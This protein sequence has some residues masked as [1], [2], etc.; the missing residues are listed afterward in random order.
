MSAVL[1]SRDYVMRL[2]LWL[3]VATEALVLALLVLLN[4]EL[5]SFSWST[6]VTTV[7]LVGAAASRNNLPRMLALGVIAL[8]AELV[9]LPSEGK[10]SMLLAGLHAAQAAT[11]TL[12]VAWTLALPRWRRAPAA[13]LVSRYFYFVVIAWLVVGPIVH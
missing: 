10:L 11:G 6:V 4:G 1:T 12:L 13:Q 2:T 8:I 5:P 3:V 9:A 7:A